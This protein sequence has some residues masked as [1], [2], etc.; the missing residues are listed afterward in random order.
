MTALLQLSLPIPCA[1]ARQDAASPEAERHLGG[2]AS[3]RA[4]VNGRAWKAHPA[5]EG[6][7][8]GQNLLQRQLRNIAQRIVLSCAAL[9]CATAGVGG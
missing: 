9:S 2:A 5:R 4:L 6:K 8:R 3:S 1:V 7:R